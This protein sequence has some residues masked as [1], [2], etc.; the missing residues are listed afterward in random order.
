MAAEEK[1]PV[2]TRGVNPAPNRTRGLAARKLRGV[3][4]HGTV[5]GSE[6][7]RRLRT[8][9]TPDTRRR[10]GARAHES[11]AATGLHLAQA[12]LVGANPLPDQARRTTFLRANPYSEVTDRFCRLPLPTLVYTTRGSS[13]RRPDSDMSTTWRETSRG[14]LPDF[15]G[16]RGRLRTPQQLRCSPRSAPYLPARGFQAATTLIQKR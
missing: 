9:R 3:P 8:T 4:R 11:R 6:T 2:R 1:R 13:P 16:P 12:R 10:P 7:D 14:P 5:L 15:H